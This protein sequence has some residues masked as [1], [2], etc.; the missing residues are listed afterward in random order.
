MGMPRK[1]VVLDA[2]GSEMWMWMQMMDEDDRT[3][4]SRLGAAACRDV[5]TFVRSPSARDWDRLRVAIQT[6]PLRS[7]LRRSMQLRSLPLDLFLSLSL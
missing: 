6:C 4:P 7:G 3:H 1:L 5:E 2:G